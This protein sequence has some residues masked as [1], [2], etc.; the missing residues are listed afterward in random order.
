[1][2]FAIHGG[3]TIREIFFPTG[4]SLTRSRETG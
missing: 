2:V 1:L 4:I 3:L